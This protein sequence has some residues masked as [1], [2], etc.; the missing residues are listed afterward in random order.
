MRVK[1]LTRKLVDPLISPDMKA[2]S[3]GIKLDAE[4]GLFTLATPRLICDRLGSQ[5]TMQ[6][7]TMIRLISDV[8]RLIEA[9]NIAAQVDTST[10][11]IVL[12]FRAKCPDSSVSGMRSDFNEWS[13]NDLP[14]YTMAFDYDVMLEIAGQLY[15]QE[16][17]GAPLYHEGSS[18]SGSGKRIIPWSQDAQ[19]MFEQMTQRMCAMIDQMDKFLHPEYLEANIKS[20]IAAQTPALLTA[21]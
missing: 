13:G 9:Y 7:D 16:F 21:Q 17:D 4:T 6:A 11:V 3:I 14:L 8:D 19:N 12:T 5:A 1:I 2:V 10:K 20:A 15:S 18:T